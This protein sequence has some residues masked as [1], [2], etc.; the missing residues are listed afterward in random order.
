[1][2]VRSILPPVLFLLFAAGAHAA[3]PRVWNVTDSASLAAAIAGSAAGD[4]IVLAHNA[5]PYNGPIALKE[6]Q[7]L[8]GAAGDPSPVLTANDDVVV[9]IAAGAT[10]RNVAITGNSKAAGIRVTGGNVTIDHCSFR[11]NA[12]AIDVAVNETASITVTSSRFQHNGSAIAISA[13]GKSNVR[14][15]LSKNM[16]DGTSASAIS[17]FSGATADLSATIAQNQISGAVCGGGCDGIRITANGGSTLTAAV[18]DNVING[19]DESAI[20]A[21]AGAGSASMA[22]AIEGN[23]INAPGTAGH[24]IY[25]ASGVTKNDTARLCAKIARNRLGDAPVRLLRGAPAATLALDPQ[26]RFTTAN[27]AEAAVAAANGGASVKVAMRNGATPDFATAT[28]K[29]PE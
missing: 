18:R 4:E 27:A 1:L 11:D 28:C 3:A 5:K 20:R 19:A 21:L 29:L 8:T 22:L 26:R 10:V 24:A 25:V 17:L 2:N 23:T 16:I 12:G 15:T 7:K 9:T 6:A 13:I 14:A